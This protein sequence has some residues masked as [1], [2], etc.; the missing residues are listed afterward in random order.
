MSLT[1]LSQDDDTRD[2]N[3]RAGRFQFKTDLYAAM[4]IIDNKVR[5]QLGEYKYNQTSGI[6]YTD[7]VFASGAN[8]QLF[9][10]QVRTNVL[11]LDFVISID[12]F[13]YDIDDDNNE[14]TYTLTVSTEYGTDT[15]SSTI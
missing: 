8:Y 9:E 3:V 2:L 11:S 1:C 5:E 10:S 4:Q 12:S 7:N 15:T 14:L 6:D 13:E